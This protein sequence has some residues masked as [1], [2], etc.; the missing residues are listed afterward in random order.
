MESAIQAEPIRVKHLDGRTLSVAVDD[1]ISPQTVKIIRGEGMPINQ[2]K[3]S[4]PAAQLQT[5]PE[6]PKGDLYVKFEIHFPSKLSEHHRRQL[7]DVLKDARG[8]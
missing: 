8:E 3:N 1:V 4:D 6:M 7:I 2:D 5:V